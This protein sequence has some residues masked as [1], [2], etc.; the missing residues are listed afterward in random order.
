MTRIKNA[1]SHIF[2]AVLEGALIATLVVGLIAGT[3]F[4]AKGGNGATNGGHGGGGG[5]HKGSAGSI[6]LVMVSDQNGNGAPNWGDQVT[7]DVS[8]AGVTN[9]YITTTCTQNGTLV[10][11]TWAGYY[12]GYMWPAA[13]TITLKSDAWTG[14]AADCTGVLYGTSVTLTFH[15][16]P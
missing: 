4:A 12:D 2:L 9:P 8:Q 11:S 16:G 13:Q 7:Y 5:G 1:A 14:G 10:L 3:A 15:V 6:A